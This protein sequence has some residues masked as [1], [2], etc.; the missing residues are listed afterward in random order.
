VLLAVLGSAR[1]LRRD[2]ERGARRGSQLSNDPRAKLPRRVRPARR[3]VE[4]RRERLDRDHL[5]RAQEEGAKDRQATARGLPAARAASSAAGYAHLRLVD[6]VVLTTG[7]R[8][9]ST[10]SPTTRRW[11]SSSSRTRASRVPEKGSTLLDQRGQRGLLAPSPSSAGRVGEG[12]RQG[13]GRP[14][15]ARYVGSLVADAHRT[16]LKGGDLRVPGRQEEPEGQA[17]LA[18]RGEPVRV[19]LRGGGR[20]GLDGTDAILDVEP[21]EAPPA[22]AL[23]LG[24]RRD[25]TDFEAFMRGE[26]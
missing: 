2:R 14:Y 18:L 24:S 20:Q 13:D 6:D 11:A 22:L 4:H 9:A 21:T 25:V 10:A 1:A 19:H 15:G 26:R 12:G 5:R 17:A 3:L 7:G 16:L 8:A 23:V